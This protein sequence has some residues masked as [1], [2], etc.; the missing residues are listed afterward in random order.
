MSRW[1]AEAH[2]GPDNANQGRMMI[3][4][5]W[6]DMTECAGYGDRE[7][8]A[9]VGDPRHVVVINH[10]NSQEAADRIRGEYSQH[11]NAAEANRLS[12]K[13][14]EGSSVKSLTVRPRN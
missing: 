3:K 8:I 12:L 7:T 10:W 13:P 4:R 11:P 14:E 5:I 2:F 9:D 1:F 6:N